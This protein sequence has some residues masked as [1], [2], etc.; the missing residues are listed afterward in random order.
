MTLLQF[1]VALLV[2]QLFGTGVRP[3]LESVAPAP[4]RPGGIMEGDWTELTGRSSGGSWI[5]AAER[6]ITLVSVSLDQSGLIGGWLAFKVA[7]KWEA[8]SNIVKVPVELTPLTP[9]AWYKARNA[10]GTWVLTRF[11]LGTASNVLFGYF[12]WYVGK[13]YLEIIDA[14]CS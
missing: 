12:A 14:L 9:I 11:L 10:I 8:W 4:H 5:G 6:A 7:A 3:F 2:A 13:H 1:I